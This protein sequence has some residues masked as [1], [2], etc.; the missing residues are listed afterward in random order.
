MSQRTIVSTT[1]QIKVSCL[2]RPFASSVRCEPQSREAKKVRIGLIDHG[3]FL[4]RELEI[5]CMCEIISWNAEL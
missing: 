2:T 5:P 4:I 1:H 3:L